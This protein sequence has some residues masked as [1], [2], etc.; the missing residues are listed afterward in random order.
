MRSLGTKLSIFGLVMLLGFAIVL[1]PPSRILAA[2]HGDAPLT[3]HDLG[4]DLNDVYL[5][6]DPNDNSRLVMIMT[7][8]GFIVPGE[9]S[10]FGIFDPAI[11]YRFE[12]ETNGDAKP[13]GDIDVRFSPRVAVGGVA[14]AQTATINLPNGRTFTAPT[15][16]SSNTSDAA[17][18]PVLTTDSQSG[19]TF[20]AGLTDDP[21]FFDIPAFG[22]FNASIRAGAPNPGVFSRG[23]DTFAGY[24]TMAIALTM[25]LSLVRGQSNQLGVLIETQRRTP[26][27]YNSRTGEVAGA[28]RWTNVDRMG[29]PAVNVVLV[30]FNQKNMHNAGSPVDDANRRF[31][32]GI[33]DTLQN[34]YH[35]DAT[36]VAVFEDLI[37]KRGDY[38]RLDLTKPNNGTN[39]EAQFPNGRRL[40]DDVVDI[41]NFL[42]NNRQPLPDNANS[43]DVPLRSSFPF[44]APSHQPRVPGTID[45][46][47]RN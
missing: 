17:P 27:F 4:A 30:P 8:H 33:L 22:R 5:F 39:P 7:V 10:N 12:L 9:N 18:T 36:S 38:L 13:D 25:P 47:T 11:R 28:G 31:W 16:N 20:F 45:D 32:P 23:R 19:V 43:N 14:Q 41:L 15:T 6:L 29:N 21:F 3:A 24:N 34:F 37:V 26:Q 1:T 40:T 44:L 46:N 35:T 2:D 42:I